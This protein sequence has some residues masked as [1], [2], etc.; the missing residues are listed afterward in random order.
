MEKTTDTGYVA[1]VCGVA[2]PKELERVLPC[3][4]IPTLDYLIKFHLP[5]PFFITGLSI[6]P[7]SLVFASFASRAANGVRD[8]S[9]FVG[10]KNFQ[11]GEGGLKQ[12]NFQ[13][14]AL[15]LA[16]AGCKGLSALEASTES[17]TKDI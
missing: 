12:V 7:V 13:L 5:S 9:R 14:E 10:Y 15:R 3:R 16:P 17:G 6:W 4:L 8:S 1:Q 2:R 11:A